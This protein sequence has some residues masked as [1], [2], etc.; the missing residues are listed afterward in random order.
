M[1]GVLADRG[2]EPLASERHTIFRHQPKRLTHPLMGDEIP[3]RTRRHTGA[4]ASM[5][6]ASERDV[7]FGAVRIPTSKLNPRITQTVLVLVHEE[8]PLNPFCRIPI[9]PHSM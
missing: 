8:V 1:D 7:V 4:L 2:F 9:G 3:A 6:P 5:H